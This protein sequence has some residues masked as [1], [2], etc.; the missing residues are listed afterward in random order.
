MYRSAFA[1]V[2]GFESVAS[3]TYVGEL[4][5]Q[6]HW[7]TEILTNHFQTDRQTMERRK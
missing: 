1:L 2:Y 4:R 3:F 6:K 7:L 5:T